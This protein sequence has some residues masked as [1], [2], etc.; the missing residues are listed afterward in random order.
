MKD[1][2]TQIELRKHFKPYELQKANVIQ[3][4]PETEEAQPVQSIR[5]KGRE[6]KKARVSSEGLLYLDD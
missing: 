2:N 4:K 6:A 3:Y 5:K 1:T